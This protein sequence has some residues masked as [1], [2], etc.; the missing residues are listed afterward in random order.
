V[1]T[2]LAGKM[3]C[4]GGRLRIRYYSSQVV[5]EPKYFTGLAKKGQKLGN[6]TY[7]T[8]RRARFSHQT[9]NNTAESEQCPH[10]GVQHHSYLL[11]IEE[12]S[13]KS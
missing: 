5:S 4:L 2:V 9:K 6:I 13:L 1:T 10:C 11:L 12:Y 3:H 7:T 8:K